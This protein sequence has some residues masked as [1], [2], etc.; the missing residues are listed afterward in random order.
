MG[1]MNDE[2]R[3]DEEEL[4]GLL[5]ELRGPPRHWIEAAQ[6]LPEARRALDEIVA[7]AEADSAYRR[8]VLADLEQALRDEGRE[9]A[10]KLIAS[11]RARLT[12]RD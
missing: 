10:P 11:L 12:E 8:R 7:R 2:P 4:A 1:L 3:R 9:P 6:E 5:G